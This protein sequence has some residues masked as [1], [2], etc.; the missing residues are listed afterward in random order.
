M[1]LPGQL[2]AV[3]PFITARLLQAIFTRISQ[4]IWLVINTR[5]VIKARN[6]IRCVHF[7]FSS[8]KER[9]QQVAGVDLSVTGH[10]DFRRR[11]RIL[12]LI[13]KKIVPPLHLD[14]D[15]WMP[16]VW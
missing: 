1:T 15:A 2:P 13:V 8:W 10:L 3:V 9:H 5:P 12:V 4:A 14:L 16:F 7:N 11:Q 6:I